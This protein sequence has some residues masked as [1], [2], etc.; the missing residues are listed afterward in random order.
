[1]VPVVS[2]NLD[3]VRS[4]FAAWERG[5]FN[6]AEWAHPEIEYVH[7]DGMAEG[8]WKGVAGM[9]EGFREFVSA[10]EGYRLEVDEFRELDDERVLVRFHRSGR[11]RTSGVKLDQMRSEGASIVHVRGGEVTRLIFYVDGE[12]ALADLGLSPEAGSSRS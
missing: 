1:L 4:I 12:R 8:S 3:L 2:A 9:A 10:W 11:G 6:S 7:A 5:D